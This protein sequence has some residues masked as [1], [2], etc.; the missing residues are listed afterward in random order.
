MRAWSGESFPLQLSTLIPEGRPR[1]D[2]S[3]RLAGE[4]LEVEGA[5]QVAREAREVE[6]V[7]RQVEKAA[8]AE[9]AV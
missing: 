5:S 3:L 4:E 9:G 8:K 1:R 7:A 2:L 6:R